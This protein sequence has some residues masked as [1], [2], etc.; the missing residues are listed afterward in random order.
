MRPIPLKL[1]RELSEDPFM[2]KC[3]ITG[4]SNVSFEHCWIYKNRQISEKWAIV[5]LRR[6]LNSSTPP[7]DVKERCKLISLERAIELLPNGLDDIYIKYPRFDWKQTYKY[8]K[9]KY[10]KN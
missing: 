4:S 6:D 9:Q 2:Q 8:L 5:P 7:K 3:C 1:R 10:D